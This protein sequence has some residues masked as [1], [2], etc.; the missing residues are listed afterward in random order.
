MMGCGFVSSL[1]V[2]LRRSGGVSRSCGA[3]LS[4]RRGLEYVSR[5]RVGILSMTASSASSS[6]KTEPSA[7]SW[8]DLAVKIPNDFLN[9]DY[10]NGEPRATPPWERDCVR[11][12]GHP[13]DEEPKFIFYRDTSYW[14]VRPPC[15]FWSFS[16]SIALLP[17]SSPLRSH[18]FFSVLSACTGVR[19]ATGF[20][21]TW[22]RRKFRTGSRKSILSATDA[23]P[24]GI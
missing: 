24:D 3:S 6:S 7:P 10:V 2:D 21:S 9:P 4:S 15:P 14:Y 11:R 23:S 20:R 17:P 22:R 16:I 12:F 5:R 8:Q 13:E 1:V 18:I 19:T